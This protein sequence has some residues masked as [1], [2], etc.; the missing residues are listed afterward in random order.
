MCFVTE[1]SESPASEDPIDIDDTPTKSFH[2]VNEYFECVSL[3]KQQFKCKLCGW[4]NHSGKCSSE[5]GAHLTNRHGIS[6]AMQAHASFGDGGARGAAERL[7][8]AR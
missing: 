1:R 8:R 3:F 5:D 4:T 2:P 7:E 6:K